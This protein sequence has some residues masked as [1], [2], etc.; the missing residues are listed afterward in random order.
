[1]ARAYTHTHSQEG[2]NIHTVPIIMDDRSVSDITITFSDE[3][4]GW[5][6]NN[7][8]RKFKWA[9]QILLFHWGILSLQRTHTDRQTDTNTKYNSAQIRFIFHCGWICRCCA[10]YNYHKND[11]NL[12][13]ICACLHLLSHLNSTLSVIIF[14]LFRV[15]LSADVCPCVCV[16]ACVWPSNF[17]H[18]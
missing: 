9:L 18:W 8:V 13:H 5:N 3:I 15:S 17:V 7:I 14:A 1:M 4:D 10:L 2:K 11:G 6:W 16:C 12:F